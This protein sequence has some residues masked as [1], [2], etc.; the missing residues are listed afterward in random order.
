MGAMTGR[1]FAHYPALNY[2]GMALW[3]GWSLVALSGTFQFCEPANPHGPIG[4]FLLIQTGSLA[5]YLFAALSPQRAGRW[6]LAPASQMAIATIASL[7]AGCLALSGQLD[8]TGTIGPDARSTVFVTGGVVLGATSGQ[9][10]LACAI[11]FCSQTPKKATLRFIQALLQSG[12]YF[13]VI[14]GMPQAFSLAVFLLTP[15]AIGSLQASQQ[16]QEPSRS[17]APCAAAALNWPLCRLSLAM[18][19]YAVAMR[20]FE[21]FF[22]AANIGNGENTS[23]P[24]AT[25]MLMLVSIVLIVVI[26]NLKGKFPYDRIYRATVSLLLFAVVLSVMFK[27][28]PALVSIACLVIIHFLS[29]L[30]RCMLA[31]VVFQSSAN[32]V[33]VFGLGMAALSAGSIIGETLGRSLL[34]LGPTAEPSPLLSLVL[35][36]ACLVAALIIFPDSRMKT[37]LLPVE[38]PDLDVPEKK[39]TRRPWMDS[40]DSLAQDASLSEREVDVFYEM[41]RGRSIQQIADKLFISPYTVKAHIRNIY[42]KLDVHSRN[43]LNALVEKGV[44]SG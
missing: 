37:L 16:H 6:L 32:P 41:V 2:L 1:L 9:Q 15:L 35:A 21:P 12:I 31:Y 43:E 38:E 36:L 24:I 26:A 33:R 3:L 17:N 34:V 7:T 8:A 28:S 19:V 4:F 42:G 13:F 11:P 30:Y 23:S 18:V 25:C 22:A 40:A 20:T 44:G 27:S 5:V 10:F 14:I 39:A 29:V